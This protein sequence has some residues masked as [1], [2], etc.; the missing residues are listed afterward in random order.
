[1]LPSTLDFIGENAF[2]RGDTREL[3]FQLGGRSENGT[4]VPDDLTGCTAIIQIKQSSCDTD[5]LET[6]STDVEGGLTLHDAPNGILLWTIN[7]ED[8]QSDVWVSGVYDLQVTYPD[9]SVRT[10]IKGRVSL[11]SD[12][13]Y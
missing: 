11:V 13:T 3:T 8:T 10:W 7:P 2:Y 1:M 6:F 4:F 5:T 9:G 12:V